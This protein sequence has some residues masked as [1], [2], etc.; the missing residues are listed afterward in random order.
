MSRAL[1]F[2]A[3]VFCVFAVGSAAASTVTSPVQVTDDQFAA[4]EESL[5]MD[6]SGQLLVGM[7][8]DWHYND[9]C[10]MSYSTDGGAT[11]APE[12]FAPGFTFFTNDPSMP[13]TGPFAIAGDP[14]VVYNPKSGLFD[15]ICQSFGGRNGHQIQLLSRTFDVTQADAGDAAHS[16]GS[17]AW[18]DVTAITTGKSNGSQ[19]G[20]NGKF[21]DHEAG[22]VDT[23]A[24]PG[25]HYG[26]LY[27]AWAEF[28]GFGK[29]PIDLSYSDNDGASWTGPIRVSDAGHQFDQDAT[30][31]VGPDGTV[32]VSFVNSQNETSTKNMT[33]M[34]AK[35]TDGG[36]TWSPSSVAAS[37]PSPAVSLPNAQYRGGTDVT[38]TVDQQSGNVVVAFGDRS[39]GALNV[40]ATHTA[41]A[42]DLSSFVQPTQ[43]KPSDQTQFFPWLQ[44]APDGRVDL[45]YYDRTCD[46]PNDVL[47]CVT[48]SST[49]DGG[50]NWT[51][52][53]VTTTGF[54]G[55]TFGVCLEDAGGEPCTSTAYFLGDYIALASNDAKAQVM[56]TGNGAQTLDAFTAAVMP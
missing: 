53:P 43:V 51:D 23:G 47:N 19:K 5:G 55:D 48:L 12:S 13:G 20:S 35:S 56:W 29:S 17:A 16:Y 34:I 54:D 41:A 40:W 39:S 26:R 7:W 1:L 30:P 28:S 50:A 9:G 14:V 21:P 33:A 31:R 18:G 8:N 46:K 22:T 3:A 4:N 11:W 38:S 42:G 52:T 24:G 37:I 2:A 25:H 6:P 10:G 27:V 45:V 32:Y 15:V 36:D 44:S 49:S